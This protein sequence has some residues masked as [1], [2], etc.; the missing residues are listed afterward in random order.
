MKCSRFFVNAE[1][2]LAKIIDRI[3][4]EK[5]W[6]MGAVKLSASNAAWEARRVP[7]D[8]IL[9]TLFKEQKIPE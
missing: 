8:F 1:S 2:I 6:T 5:K 3:S 9:F 7:C 4:K